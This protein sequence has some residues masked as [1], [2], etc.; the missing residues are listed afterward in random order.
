MTWDFLICFKVFLIINRGSRGPDL[1]DILKVLK[2]TINIG[3]HPQSLISHFKPIINYKNLKIQY[4]MRNKSKTSRNF[5]PIEPQ[6]EQPV[7]KLSKNPLS[8][9]GEEKMPGQR[10]RPSIT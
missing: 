10:K 5:P 6:I 2:M 4:K 9:L 7:K 1:V 3:I 8:K